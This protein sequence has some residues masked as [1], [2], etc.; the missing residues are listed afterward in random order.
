MTTKPVVLDV[1]WIFD[2]GRIVKAERPST[3]LPEDP[4]NYGGE[5]PE[6]G[7]K[8]PPYDMNGL[9]GMLE[10]TT[11]HTRCVKQ[12]AADVV[13]RGFEL[14]ARELDDKQKASNEEED[15][16]G[17]FVRNVEEGD[18]RGDE[19]FK[20]RIQRSHEDHESVGWAVLEVSRNRQGMLDGLWHV[21]GHTVRAHK[22][23]RRFAQMRD[24]KLVY[25]KRFGLVGD[26]DR[27]RGG[28]SDTPIR[29]PDVRANELIVIRNY[30][31]R[32]S[33]YGLPDHIPALAA[34][35]GWR[36][37]AEFNVKFFDNNAVPAYA[38]VI[39]GATL[40]PELEETIRGFFQQIKGD[41]HRTLIIPVPG[42]Q[43]DDSS[44]PII[45]F[46]RLSMEIKDASFRN[47]KQ[48]NA[49]EICIA[50]G[51]PPYRVG[52]PIVGSLGGNTAAEMTRIYNDSVVQPRQ[53]TWE[54]RLNRA[55]LGA[56]GLAVATWMLKANELDLRDETADLAKAKMLYELG[57][58]NV[59]DNARFFGHDERED[60][61]GSQYI[62]VPLAPGAPSG[63]MPDVLTEP[64]AK[65][66]L[67]EVGELTAL[68][69]R[70]TT[71]L[72]PQ[73]VDADRIAA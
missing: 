52:W 34:L 55:L 17:E 9:I 8:T 25:F 58:N 44:R 51:M 40:T 10:T 7:L 64:V 2:D 32:S 68:R 45:R 21:P 33:Y 36:A 70:I 66:W 22:D 46:E 24:S 72:G 4:F 54:D 48:D 62:P 29:D 53:E 37:Q 28:W 18:D 61:G 26:V 27:A 38:V 57:V 1:G 16:W 43:G 59:N 11:L 39:E 63:P 41:P 60:P 50:H 19:S 35:A 15:G 14:R 67:A 5:G 56:K 23:G 12:K 6:G 69:K 47:Y 20:E 13:G 65:A 42:I 3:Q 30:S 71:A 73:L 31:P 49:L